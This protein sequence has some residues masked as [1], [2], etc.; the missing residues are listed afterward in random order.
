M[1]DVDSAQMAAADAERLKVQ[2][3]MAEQQAHTRA[4]ARV[5]GNLKQKVGGAG[6]VCVCGGGAYLLG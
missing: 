1:G 2:R 3:A 4:L 6:G 5:G